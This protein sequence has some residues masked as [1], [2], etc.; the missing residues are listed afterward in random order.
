MKLLSF[1]SGVLRGAALLFASQRLLKGI[2]EALDPFAK[3]SVC[4][5]YENTSAKPPHTG[6]L[7]CLLL[8]AAF[9]MWD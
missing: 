4:W 8:R 2:Q 3:S 7:I 6:P 5:G 1:K 9:D